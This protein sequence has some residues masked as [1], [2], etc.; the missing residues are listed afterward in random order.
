V[1]YIGK[2]INSMRDRHYGWAKIESEGN[3]WLRYNFIITNFGPITFMVTPCTTFASNPAFAEIELFKGYF[4]SH[5]EAPPLN[6]QISF[7]Y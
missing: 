5:L 4:E 3:N 6:R 1:I 2:T 7:G